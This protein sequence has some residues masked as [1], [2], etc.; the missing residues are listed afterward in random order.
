MTMLLEAPIT[1]RVVIEDT[2]LE[3]TLPCRHGD[4]GAE[5]RWVTRCCSEPVFACAKHDAVALASA[6]RRFAEPGRV[7]LCTACSAVLGTD[8]TFDQVFRRHRV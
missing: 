4:A 5:W 7:H 1:E 2:V 8:L 6:T 3:D